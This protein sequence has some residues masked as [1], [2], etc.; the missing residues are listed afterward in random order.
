MNVRMT[1]A[2]AVA[3]LV[4]SL[5]LVGSALG[6]GYPPEATRAMGERYEAMAAYYLGPQAPGYTPQA[7]RALGDR[8]S[9]MARYQRQAEL[10]TARREAAAFDWADAGIGALAAIG[11]VALLGLGALGIRSHG[12]RPASPAAL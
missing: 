7:L 8:W 5:G 2:V 6:A 1:A 10:D 3:S 9:A 12:E 11:A 4:G